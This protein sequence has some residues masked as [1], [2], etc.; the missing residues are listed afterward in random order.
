MA[1]PDEAVELEEVEVE[2]VPPAVVEV[3]QLAEAEAKA[4]AGVEVEAEAGDGGI[5]LV[6]IEVFLDNDNTHILWYTFLIK[7][8]VPSS[9]MINY[10]D[11]KTICIWYDMCMIVNVLGFPLPSDVVNTDTYFICYMFPFPHLCGRDTSVD[12]NVNATLS[13]VSRYLFHL[14]RV[15]F[16]NTPCVYRW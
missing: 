4:E 7:L 10:E 14:F 5:V 1:L 16:L 3:E 8:V 13:T 12:V 15:G 6:E 9:F 2:E 11:G